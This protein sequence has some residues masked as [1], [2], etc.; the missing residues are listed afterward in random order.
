MLVKNAMT[1]KRIIKFLPSDSFGKIVRVLVKGGISGAPVINKKGNLVGVVSEKDLF[2]KLF[3]SEKVFYEDPEYYMD[4]NR[5]EEEAVVVRKLKAKDFMTRRLITIGPDEH[6]LKA[7]SMFLKNKIRR[8]L[9]VK[10]GKLV[11]VVTTNDVYKHFLKVLST[12]DVK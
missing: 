5:I 7:I 4:F 10:N 12:N 8:L 6:I 9:V 1:S 11:G 2:Y 3:P